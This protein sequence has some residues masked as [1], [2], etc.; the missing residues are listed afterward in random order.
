MWLKLYCIQE[1]IAFPTVAEPKLN[2][3]THLQTKTA[4]NGYS[5]CL[6]VG[7]L[8]YWIFVK[9]LQQC[10]WQNAPRLVD[11]K[12]LHHNT[13]THFT[14]VSAENEW[15]EFWNSTLLYILTRLISNQLRFFLTSYQLPERVILQQQASIQKNSRNVEF[16]AIKINRIDK[17]V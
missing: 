8:V 11:W 6:M 2:T 7:N 12:S 13:W 4:S 10:N 17:N 15:T 1:L 9:Q 16:Y 14:D 5:H 3:K